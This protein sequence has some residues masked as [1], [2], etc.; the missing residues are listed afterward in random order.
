MPIELKDQES[1]ALN[2]EGQEIEVYFR[3]PN[4]PE[5]VRYLASTLSGSGPEAMEQMLS[6]GISLAQSC[7]L[8]I[9]EGDIVIV[10]QGRARGLVT[11]PARPGYD[12]NWKQLLKEKIPGLLLMLANRLVKNAASELEVRE[13][14]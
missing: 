3:S 9:K 6:A 10:D 7:L 4:A 5:M 13:K 2:L 12:H 11:D 1:L 8:G 14:N